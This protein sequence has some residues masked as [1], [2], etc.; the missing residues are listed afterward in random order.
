LGIKIRRFNLAIANEINIALTG[1]DLYK[2]HTDWL[3]AVYK[4]CL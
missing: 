4:M 3:G 2:T 1:S